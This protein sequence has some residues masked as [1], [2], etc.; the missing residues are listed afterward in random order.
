[1]TASTPS[2]RRPSSMTVGADGERAPRRSVDVDRALGD[3]ARP[4]FGE[5]VGDGLGGDG[6]A[7]AA[8]HEVLGLGVAEDDAASL[9]AEHQSERQ[10]VERAAKAHRLGARFADRVVGGAGHLFEVA[11]R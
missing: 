3:A 10:R 6:V 5:H 1:M 9:V 8:G 11:E 2:G 4:A 7:V